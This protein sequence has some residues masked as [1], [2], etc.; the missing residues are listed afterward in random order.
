MLDFT[1]GV[2]TVTIEIKLG[3]EVISSQRFQGPL[4]LIYQQYIDIVN[5]IAQ[6]DRPIKVT[7]YGEK[8]L[9]SPTGELKV[10]PSKVMF[11]NNVYLNVFDLED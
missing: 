1:V 6:D 2:G 11:A 7:A 10:L 3:N 8:H 5:Q 9:E 4:Q